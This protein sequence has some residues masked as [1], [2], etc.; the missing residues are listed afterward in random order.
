[1]KVSVCLASHNGS[2]FIHA[3]IDSILQQ[4]AQQDELII[5]DDHS[6]DNT[7]DIIKDF[8]DKR[9]ILL[10]SN[11]QLGHVASFAKAIKHAT[12]DIIVLSDQDDIWTDGRQKIVNDAFLHSN[13]ALVAGTFNQIDERGEPLAA[14]ERRL[15]AKDSEKPLA[16]IIGIF[17]GRRPYFGCAMAFRRELTH[18]VLPIPRWVESHDLWIAMAANMHGGIKHLTSPLLYKRLHAANVSTPTRRALPI[19]AISRIKFLACLLI[20]FWRAI[21]LKSN[22]ARSST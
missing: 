9:V 10:A 13:C 1:M 11:K 19:V 21:R 7:V 3:Q 22:N 17:L 8:D 18:L 20:L 14:P 4:L 2:Q 16:N 15:K 6:Q 12:G 5:V